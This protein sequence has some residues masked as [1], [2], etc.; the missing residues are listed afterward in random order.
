MEK[1]FIIECRRYE[2]TLVS[3]YVY[4]VFR[5]FE[6]ASETMWCLYDVACDE[7]L[8]DSHNQFNRVSVVKE[9]DTY[10]LEFDSFNAETH[11]SEFY[12]LKTY[13]VL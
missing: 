13:D 3:S 11:T 7:L 2:D 1:I 5:C 9:Q 8:Q 6:D 10:L 4:K 12:R